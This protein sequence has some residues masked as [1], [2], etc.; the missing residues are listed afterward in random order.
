MARAPRR[1]AQARSA[2]EPITKPGWSTRLTTGRR[3]WS[4]RS[5]KRTSLSEASGQPAAV[6]LGIGGEHADGVAVEP[7][8][9]ADQAAAV[10]LAELE[11]AAG[12][13]HGGEDRAH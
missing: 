5:A 8:Q 12:V 6:V 9:R 11:H 1:M 10:P 2:P 4:H 3:N 7:R 13:E